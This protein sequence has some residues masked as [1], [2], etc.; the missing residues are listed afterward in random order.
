MED[1]LSVD[2]SSGRGTQ[3]VAVTCDVNPNPDERTGR[4]AVYKG[5][6]VKYVNVLQEA[7]NIIVIPPFD[8]LVLR[9]YWDDGDGRDFDSA[10]AFVNTNISSVDN[11]FVGWSRQNQ[12]TQWQVGPDATPY[13]IH[14][15]DNLSSGLE[16]VLIQMNYLLDAPGLNPTNPPGEIHVDIYGNWYASIGTGNIRITF[17]A[18][19][20]G[21]MIRDGFNFVNN[22]G[23]QVYEGDGYTRVTATG[24][25]NWSD[26]TSLYSKIGTVKY[27]METRDCIIVLA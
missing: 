15:G 17:T 7:G 20:G 10:T 13:L 24:N 6:E 3:D 1:W 14:G 16:S 2:K 23:E 22:G 9:Y 19:L 26:I 25:N 11:I 8:Y 5:A 12:T 21:Q 18:Y 4:I 27:D